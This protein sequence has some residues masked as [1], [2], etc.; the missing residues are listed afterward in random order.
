MV[1]INPRFLHLFPSDFMP[2]PNLGLNSAGAAVTCTRDSTTPLAASD[3]NTGFDHIQGRFVGSSITC[4][5]MS[6][7]AGKYDKNT[8]VLSFGMMSTC[9]VCGRNNIQSRRYAQD[10]H[11]P[12]AT[13]GV[14]LVPPAPSGRQ[15]R[16]ERH[17]VLGP[18]Q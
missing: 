7:N 1:L 5:G 8:C 10:V 13:R 14:L 9:L 6:D 17:M 4:T 18:W 2:N 15:S 3:T 16:R 11:R 12:I